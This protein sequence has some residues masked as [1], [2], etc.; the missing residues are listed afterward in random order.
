MATVGSHGHSSTINSE[1][2]VRA[3]FDPILKSA[4][5]GRANVGVERSWNTGCRCFG[6]YGTGIHITVAEDQGNK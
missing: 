6:A 4:A 5:E 3:Y 1:I 2:A